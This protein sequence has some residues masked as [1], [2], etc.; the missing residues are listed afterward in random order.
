VA[1][2]AAVLLPDARQ[3]TGDV[4]EGDQRNVERIARPD[5]AS[6]LHRCVD[7]Q[8]AGQ[9]SGLLR[10]DADGASAQARESNDDVL[11]PARLDLEP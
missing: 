4:H 1:D 2:D 3:E 10:D 5:E 6:R 11:R 7:V 9:D 8:G